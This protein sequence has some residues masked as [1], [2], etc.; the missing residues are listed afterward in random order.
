MDLWRSEC[1]SLLIVQRE[2]KLAKECEANYRGSA[3]FSR[4]DNRNRSFYT[5]TSAYFSKFPATGKNGNGSG[6]G[7]GVLISSLNQIKPFLSERNERNSESE[8]QSREPA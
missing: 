8:A 2:S 7:E 4:M 6:V 1:S 5:L 3:L